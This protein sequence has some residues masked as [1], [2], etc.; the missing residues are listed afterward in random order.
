MKIKYQM[1]K[2]DLVDREFSGTVEWFNAE[3]GFGYIKADDGECCFVHFSN[4]IMDGFKCLKDGQR[5]VFEK[6]LDNR[7]LSVKDVRVMKS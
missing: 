2:Y 6:S 4:L 3:K 1:D 7:G 5:V